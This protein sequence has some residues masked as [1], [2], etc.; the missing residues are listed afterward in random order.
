MCLILG[1]LELQRYQQVVQVLHAPAF[2]GEMAMMVDV[3]P[4]ARCVNSSP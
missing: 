4:D 2:I 3:L 1:T